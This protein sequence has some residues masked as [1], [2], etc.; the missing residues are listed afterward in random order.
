MIFIMLFNCI[1]CSEQLRA[2][3]WE[4]L[5][6][7]HG[8][9]QTVP[10]NTSHPI[11]HFQN[12]STHSI[13]NLKR[14]EVEG[15]EA[16]VFFVGWQ[17]SGHS[18]IGSLLDGHPDVVIAHELFLFS[19]LPQFIFMEDAKAQLFHSLYISSIRASKAGA[20][21]Q[22]HNEKGYNL[23][24]ENSWQG[25]FRKLRVI[26]DKTA[27]DVTNSFSHDA[28]MFRYLLNRLSEIVG[29]PLKVI[30][31]VRNPFDMVA[32]LTLYRGST[33]RNVKVHATETNKYN[34]TSLLEWSTGVILRKAEALYRIEQNNYDWSFMRLYS[35]DFIED[36]KATMAALC[37]FLGIECT[38]KYLQQCA[39]KTFSSVSKSRHLIVWNPYIVAE[40]NSVI[41]TVPFLRRYSFDGM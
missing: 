1:F 32:T 16:F 41:Q 24:L 37:T 11:P 17:R 30:N 6:H 23:H 38:E 18:I 10:Q 31:V 39:D 8:H 28:I 20:R 26:G 22:Y 21:S 5:R 34:N 14:E 4:A 40:I 9:T 3:H 12:S 25:S 19:N 13:G 33:V 35:E 29:V 15:V 36:P 7:L 27:G 2:Q